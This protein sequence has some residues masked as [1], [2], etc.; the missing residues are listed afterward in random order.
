MLFDLRQGF[1][2]PKTL[3]YL[4]VPELESY[5]PF[6]NS[7]PPNIYI[8]RS[9]CLSVHSTDANQLIISIRVI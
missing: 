3:A 7:Y 9:T 1:S 8:L 2:T 4:P 5:R 6:A